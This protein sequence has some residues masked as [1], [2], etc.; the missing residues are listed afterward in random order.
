MI[1]KADVDA[2]LKAA[3]HDLDSMSGLA[4]IKQSSRLERA[5]YLGLFT[6]LSGIAKAEDVSHIL[7]R[8]I[9]GTFSARP[10][11]DTFDSTPTGQAFKSLAH[12]L[13]QPDSSQ[14][15]VLEA[16][17]QLAEHVDRQDHAW[18][19]RAREARQSLDDLRAV[20]QVAW[21]DRSAVE[22]AERERQRSETYRLI[23]KLEDLVRYIALVET[24]HRRWMYPQE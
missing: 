22:S 20:T 4:W 7:V 5:Y 13:L 3:R 21:S 11:D 24:D 6:G 10:A 15:V 12:Q 2:A 17:Q 8:A 23:G 18:N 16:F 9:A 14:D 19:S 1:E